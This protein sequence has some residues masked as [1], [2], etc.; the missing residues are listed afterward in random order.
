MDIYIYAYISGCPRLS[1]YLSIY[2]HKG[3]LIFCLPWHPLAWP[4]SPQPLAQRGEESVGSFLFAVGLDEYAAMGAA[5]R[6]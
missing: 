3:I 4:A 2:T 6:G 5:P 1:I